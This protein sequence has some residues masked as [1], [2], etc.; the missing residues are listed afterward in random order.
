M[1]RV[2]RQRYQRLWRLPLFRR[3]AAVTAAAVLIASISA[4]LGPLWLT[5][6]LIAAGAAVIALIASRHRAQLA[7]EAHMVRA[8]LRSRARCPR[9]PEVPGLIAEVRTEALASGVTRIEAGSWPDAVRALGYAMGRDRGFQMD[10]LRRTAAGRLAEVWGRTAVPADER[11]RP[12]GLAAVADR[13]AAILEKPETEVLTAF[14]DGV[15]ASLHHHGPAFECRFLSYRPEP[16]T[17]RDSLLIASFLFHSLSWNEPSKRAEAVI[18]HAFP[19]AVA[20]FLLPGDRRADPR[21]PSGLS[22]LRA[23][24]ET[25]TGLVAVDLAAAGSNC[26]VRGAGAG[27]GPILACDLHLPLTMPN[28]LYEVDMS[29]PGGRLRGLAA[30]GLPVVLTG[31]NQRIAWGV[32][33][34]GADVLD[35]EPATGDS[36]APAGQART[37]ERIRVRGRPDVALPVTRVG[38]M[39]VS[40]SPLLG[41]QVALRWTGLDPRSCDLKFQRLAQARTV[42]EGIAVLDDAQ[43]PALNVLIAD[44]S[45]R[46]AHLATGLLP[47]RV[48]GERSAAPRYLDGPARPRLVDPPSGVLVSAND[49]ALPGGTAG[50]SYDADPGYRA[51]R[52]RRILAGDLPATAAGMRALQHDTAADLYLPYRDLAL[53]S[54]AGRD[55]HVAG[56]LAAWDGRADAGSRAFGVLVRLR[57]VLAERILAPYLSACRELDPDFRYPFRSVDAPVLAILRSGDPSLLP[58]GE[59]SA[60]MAAFV[61][62]CLDQA[63]A[64]LR[65]SSGRPGLPAWG[66]LNSVGLR[67]PLEGLAPWGRS[68]LGVAERPQAGALHS[69]RTCV[70]G[71]GAAGRAVLSLG[72]DPTA[73]FEMPGGQVGHPLSPQFDNRHREWS[74]TVPRGRRR[75]RP[76]CSFVLRPA[77]V[78]SS[79]SPGDP[80]AVRSA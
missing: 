64:D 20:S 49:A 76:G 71:F 7:V 1:C 47:S 57:Q 6:A 25:A 65:L 66:K 18:R 30:A 70:P 68:L 80:V 74:S 75:P 41:Q 4:V 37:T 51:R 54:L 58:R 77:R 53:S 12:L 26:W 63:L 72:A 78:T 36:A 56:L 14:T 27:G 48:N 5:A 61:A 9:D 28:L 10:L 17:I 46:M 13:A 38:P 69:V 29:W 43:G 55:D 19:G 2:H 39:P 42:G 8:L 31:T 59:E 24:G 15:N 33:N 79:F 22:G 32:T 45:G 11:F 23:A 73:Q 67:H 35:L 44:E 50:L 34:L 3:A 40:P 16:W 21:V 62:R 52:I 60:G